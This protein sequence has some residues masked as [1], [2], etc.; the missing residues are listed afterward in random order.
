MY[1]TVGPTRSIHR[2]KINCARNV[3]GGTPGKKKGEGVTKG[4]KICQPM[5][6]VWPWV[7]GKA[8]EARRQVDW[9]RWGLLRPKS[10]S[11]ESQVSQEWSSCH[12]QWLA[13]SSW[14]W[15]GLG[16]NAEIDFRGWKGYSVHD[17]G[18]LSYTRWR[19]NKCPYLMSV[20]WCF[21]MR[22]HI[23]KNYKRM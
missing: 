17:I 21:Y 22:D 1:V 6:Q 9:G 15:H 7:E 8:K 14:E 19:K 10:P 11:K 18:T 3:L 12:T 13:G 23:K 4:W 20:K 5:P 16:G 2:D